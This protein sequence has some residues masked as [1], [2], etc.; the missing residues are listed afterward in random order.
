M[1]A[2]ARPTSIRIELTTDERAELEILARSLAVSHRTVVRARLIVL[3]ADGETVASTARRV[4]LRRRI[5]YKWAHRFVRK[6]IAGLDDEPRSGRPG[7]FSPR[8]GDA[9]GEARM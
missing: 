2:M 8:S 5:V 1:G 9:S 7:R 3:L 6:R 4:Q